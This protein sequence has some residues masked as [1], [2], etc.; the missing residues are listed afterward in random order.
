[1]SRHLEIN[2]QSVSMNALS[3]T[4]KPYA[5]SSCDRSFSRRYNLERHVE[6]SHEVGDN[7][8]MEANQPDY[9]DVDDYE[10]PFKKRRFENS[11]DSESTED[12][13]SSGDSEKEDSETED[14]ESSGDDESFRELEDNAAYREWYAQAMEATEEMRAEKYEKYINEGMSEDG[15]KEKAYRKT[16]W[17]TKRVFF[18]RYEDFL[19]SYLHLKDDDTHQ[20]VVEDL[21]EKVDK[22][23]DVDKAM[24]RVIP[25][26]RTN[27]E[28]LFHQDE[29][30]DYEDIEGDDN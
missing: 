25:K 7:P 17:E 10:P 15:A 20:D 6:N 28:G 14:D 22:G 12:E 19:S 30:D 29:E 16:L 5:C 23:M 11:E 24:K 3:A 1:M 8:K 27:F 9:S 13:D 21:E 2:L 4:D 26:Y 18:N